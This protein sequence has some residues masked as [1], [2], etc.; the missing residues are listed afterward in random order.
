MAASGSTGWFWFNDRPK[1]RESVFNQR[2]ACG[3]AEHRRAMPEGSRE[4]RSA[5][6]IPPG[7]APKSGPTQGRSQDA[8]FWHFCRS[9]NFFSELTGGIADAQPLANTIS[10]SDS[11]ESFKGASSPH[12]SPPL[13]VEERVPAGRERRWQSRNNRFSLGTGI[14]SGSPPGYERS[15]CPVNKNLTCARSQPLLIRPRQKNS[16]SREG[17]I[18]GTFKILFAALASAAS[19]SM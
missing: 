8:R 15:R 18:T 17:L 4:L 14:T 12:P 1:R 7:H 9:A 11:V 10:Q 19:F 6:T 13:G 3:V 16:A 2:L 5:V